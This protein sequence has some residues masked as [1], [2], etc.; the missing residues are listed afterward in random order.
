MALKPLMIGQVKSTPSTLPNRVMRDGTLSLPISGSM[1]LGWTAPV[2]T[3]RFLPV[4]LGEKKTTK[5][6]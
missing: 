6:S 2:I 3:Q 1:L 4:Q 5:M